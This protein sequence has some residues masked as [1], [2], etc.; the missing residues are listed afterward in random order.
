M[1]LGNIL[2]GAVFLPAMVGLPLGGWVLYG[3]V[4]PESARSHFVLVCRVAQWDLSVIK[5]A[6]LGLTG[7][8]SCIGNRIA[9]QLGPEPRVAQAEAVRGFVIGSVKSRFDEEARAGFSGSP[10]LAA[11]SQ[12]LMGDR[13]AMESL[14]GACPR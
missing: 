10:E 11:F 9:G 12:T 13:V 5:A 2:V 1:K 4:T 6:D 3:D 8:C 14:S 7:D